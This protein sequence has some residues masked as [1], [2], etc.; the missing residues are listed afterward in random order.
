MKMIMVLNLGSTS[1]KFKL[2]AMDAQTPLRAQ[3]AVDAIGSGRSVLKIKGGGAAIQEE[4][5]IE[6]HEAAFGQCITVLRNTGVLKDA[7]ELS[8]VGYKAVLAGDVSGVQLV[9]PALLAR[10]EAFVPL[11]PAHNPAYIGMMKQMAAKEP[12]LKQY[13]CFETSFH[14]TVPLKRAVYGVPKEWLEWGVRRY[15]FHGASHSYIAQKVKTLI[16]AARRVVS[17]HLGGSSSICAVLDGKSVASSMGATPQSGL[18]H[19]NRV[20]DFDPFCLPMLVKRLGSLEAVL[21]ALST[22]SGFLG[23]SG[24][25]NDMRQIEAA[26]ME[27]DEN[28]MLAVDA[29][30]DAITGYIGMDTAYLGGLDVIAFTGGIGEHSAITRAKALAPLA[31]LGVELDAEANMKNRLYINTPESRVKVL[32]LET[33]EEWMI[34]GQV[35]KCLA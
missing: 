11:A 22:Q 6:S 27:G 30:C 18:F 28:A 1:F 24:I 33:D 26:A 17:V 19:N 34:A 32:V 10:M 31:Y 8:A 4:L 3:G 7:A 15:G 16:P 20:G 29:F 23:L 12:Q 13:A 14:A 9:T 35:E 21:N 2:F 5:D 25:S